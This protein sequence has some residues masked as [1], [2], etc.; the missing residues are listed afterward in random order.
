MSG[1]LFRLL[2]PIE[3]GHGALLG[4]VE[5]TR[6]GEGY[7]CPHQDHDGWRDRPATR[8]FF[9]TAQAEEAAEA[10]RRSR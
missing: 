4:L 5:A 7:Y 9:T 3:P 8:P 6:R 10:A 1:K 2:C